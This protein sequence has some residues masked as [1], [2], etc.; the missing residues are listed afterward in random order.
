MDMLSKKE[1]VPFSIL[2][3][4]FFLPEMFVRCE[5]KPEVKKKCSPFKFWH[6]LKPKGTD[7]FYWWATWPNRKRSVCR[8]VPIYRKDVGK[9]SAQIEGVNDIVNH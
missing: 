7:F 8:C 3:T 1:T 4:F 5:T 9:E 6:T 2:I